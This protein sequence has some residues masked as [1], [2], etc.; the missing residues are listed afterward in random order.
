M[1]IIVSYTLPYVHRV[2]VGIEAASE[3]SALTKAQAFF[4]EGSIW[5][6]T[7]RLPLLLDDFEEQGDSGDVLEFT[8]EQTLGE[9]E[10][11]PPPDASVRAIRRG[12]AARRAA[13][14]LVAAY[15]RGEA[16]G[17]VDWEDLNL[18]YETALLAVD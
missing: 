6:D 4:D 15:R 2:M 9:G 12:N 17:S 7:Q 18:A 8:I 16:T 10:D 13:E 14:L 3:E 1:K 5:D 11:Y